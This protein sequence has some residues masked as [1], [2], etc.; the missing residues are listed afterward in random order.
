VQ[1]PQLGLEYLVEPDQ[2]GSSCRSVGERFRPYSNHNRIG[3]HM[4]N[5]PEDTVLYFTNFGP[6][7]YIDDDDNT[8]G[9][10][11]LAGCP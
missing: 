6:I 3:S 5:F 11:E 2:A 1:K 4:T 7:R 9:F 10:L 8:T